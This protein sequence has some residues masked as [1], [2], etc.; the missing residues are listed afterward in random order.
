[1]STNAGRPRFLNQKEISDENSPDDGGADQGV[2]LVPNPPDLR[3]LRFEEEI[4]RLHPQDG[5]H[6]EE[7]IA[8]GKIPAEDHVEE[9]ESDEQ[10]D[11]VQGLDVDAD[12]PEMA[13]GEK[14]AGEDHRQ[15]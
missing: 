12:P 11:F 1:M 14:E 9:E 4:G 5:E 10:L 3:R 6:V 2:G 15:A 13:A 8:D 7:D